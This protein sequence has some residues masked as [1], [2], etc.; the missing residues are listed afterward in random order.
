MSQENVEIIREV[1]ALFNDRGVRAATDAFGHLLSPDFALEEAAD[2]PDPEPH[3]GRDAFI[4][5]LA[6]VEESFD[7]L[8]MEPLEIVDL[9]EQIIVVVSMRGK[10]RGSS[11]PV[12]MN[13]A[14]L[15]TMHD[16]KATSLRDFPTKAEALN[17]AGLVE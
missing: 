14:Q 17:A 5:N 13:F 7:E 6:K 1:F 15:W 16:G 9:G 8:R 3:T 2:L 4:A 11:A 12:Q 10:G